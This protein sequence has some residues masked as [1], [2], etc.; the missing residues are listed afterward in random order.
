MSDRTTP[1]EGYL[2]GE[3]GEQAK[4]LYKETAEW[5]E[6]EERSKNW[7]P[8]DAEN[9]NEGILNI[10]RDI[11]AVKD[12]DPASPEAQALVKRLKDFITEHLYVCSDTVLASLGA[13]YGAGGEYA[14][15]IDRTGGEGTALFAQKAIEIFCKYKA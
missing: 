12:G 1:T 2:I 8:E 3:R 14:D 6:Y 10:F 9:V 7:T 13:M 15:N 4:A 5:K 11:G